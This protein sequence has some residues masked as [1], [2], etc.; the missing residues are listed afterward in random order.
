MSP[1]DP[2]TTDLQSTQSPASRVR[3]SRVRTLIFGTQIVLVASL[4]VW[5][6]T[7]STA[8]AS[9]SLW[10][11]FVYCFP[12]EFLIATVPHEPILLYFGKL[13]SPLTV[14]LI[15]A[16]GT[17][18]TEI[19]NYSVFT[20]VADMEMSRRVTESKFVA[21]SVG[22]FHKAPFSAL[23][24]AGFTP[25]PFYPFRFLVVLAK[26]PLWKYIAAVTVSRTPRF[27]LFA[28][29]GGMFIIP[30]WVLVVGFLALILLVNVP[31]VW[32]AWRKRK[33]SASPE[34]M[35]QPENVSAID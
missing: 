28:L 5:W 26:Y 19:L 31:I 6:L 32:Q 21:K 9:T 18:L 1:P 27:Y 20:Y 11:L 2:T 33:V 13:Y 14:A 23:C 8:G 30:D 4:L 7:S 10:V 3:R 12:A 29:A 16:A 34:I 17:V 25:I 35:L 22:W 15:S 24:V